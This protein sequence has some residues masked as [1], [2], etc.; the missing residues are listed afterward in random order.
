MKE[1]VFVTG[2]KGKQ[3]EAQKWL[4]RSNI[5]VSCYDYDIYEPDV[6]DIDFIAKTKVLQAYDKVNKPCIALDAGFYINN[7]PNNPGFPGAFPKRELLNKIG[8]DGLLEIMKDVE[9]R[10]CY[11]KECLAYY[12]GE[13][14]E[15]FYGVSK[16][17]VVKEK[18]TVDNSKKWSEL[19][20]IF[21]PDNCNKT[22]S[23]MTE[24]ERENR[25]DNHTNALKEFSE[26]FYKK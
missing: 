25:P 22:L 10:S 15:Y 14:I 21:R 13:N 20:Y 9:D 6:N 8:I 3:A 17:D 2:N 12:D 19:W 26:W 1:I 4:D 24:E 23:E 16:G 5:V 18:A 11:F 7:Y